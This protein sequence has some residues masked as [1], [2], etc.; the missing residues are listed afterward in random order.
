MGEIHSAGDRDKQGTSA[1]RESAG[2]VCVCGRLLLALLACWRRAIP[3]GRAGQRSHKL[4]RSALSKA[5]AA[6][7]GR[8]NN[9]GSRRKLRDQSRT[10]PAGGWCCSAAV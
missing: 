3:R 5:N 9:G 1:Q 2:L 10:V 6:L 7:V 8:E 4:S